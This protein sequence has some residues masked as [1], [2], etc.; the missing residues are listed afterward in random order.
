MRGLTYS[1]REAA[2]QKHLVFGRI[3]QKRFPVHI[4]KIGPRGSQKLHYEGL[5]CRETSDFYEEWQS[6]V[7]YAG[8]TKVRY[9]AN[10]NKDDADFIRFKEYT[11]KFLE[12]KC[13]TELSVREV[14]N[15]YLRTCKKRCEEPITRIRFGRCLRMVFPDLGLRRMDS[16]YS[17]K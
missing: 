9:K 5:V 17:E 15:H 1:E 12:R 4:R 10:P 16:I 14:F 6:C 7:R 3:V 13:D 8:T 2:Y 11:S